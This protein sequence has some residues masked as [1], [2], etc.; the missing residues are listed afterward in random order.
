[1]PHDGHDA[2]GAVTLGDDAAVATVEVD[3]GDDTAADS[4][5]TPYPFVPAQPAAKR[6]T[7]AI[8][9]VSVFIIVF[10]ILSPSTINVY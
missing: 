7:P 2:S 1:V 9:A 4:A 10:I 5:R 8:I 6:Q 3:P